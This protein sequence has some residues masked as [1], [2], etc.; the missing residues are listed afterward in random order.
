MEDELVVE[1]SDAEEAAGAAACAT[2][3]AAP[4]GALAAALAASADGEVEAVVDDPLGTTDCEP[5]VAPSP[6][7]P[8]PQPSSSVE[9]AAATS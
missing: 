5:D 2:D 3:D 9:V 8:P 6:P 7:L 4:E 1:G